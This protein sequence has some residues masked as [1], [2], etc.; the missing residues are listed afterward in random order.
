MTLLLKKLEHVD[1]VFDRLNSIEK[2]LRDIKTQN[3]L[4]QDQNEELKNNIEISSNKRGQSLLS[5]IREVQD[6]KKMNATSQEKN[7]GDFGSNIIVTSSCSL[8]MLLLMN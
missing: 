8:S 3:K 6:T 7:G 5:L 2:E 4:L 1:K